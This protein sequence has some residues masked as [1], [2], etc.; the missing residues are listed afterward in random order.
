MFS[1]W[2]YHPTQ[3]KPKHE[4]AI[5]ANKL[6]RLHE[7]SGSQ[8]KRLSP[9]TAEHTTTRVPLIYVALGKQL[10]SASEN[11]LKQTK[12]HHMEVN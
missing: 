3:S 10:K 8:A 7:P 1:H 11:L 5:G 9:V 12:H 4:L 6:T 2:P